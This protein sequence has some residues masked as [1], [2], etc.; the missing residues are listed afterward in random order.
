MLEDSIRDKLY[1]HKGRNLKKERIK[2]LYTA[3]RLDK[4][5]Y[6]SVKYSKFTGEPS[7]SR[8]LMDK[9]IEEQ[10]AILEAQFTLFR[11]IDK[12]LYE[13]GIRI[14][15]CKLKMNDFPDYKDKII[16]EEQMYKRRMAGLDS[17]ES[18]SYQS[19]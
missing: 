11:K 19:D 3:P 6:G 7:E 18:L 17:D 1:D 2:H 5:Y 4:S 12:D 14:N 16:A 15:F 10:N 9:Q 8:L 13:D